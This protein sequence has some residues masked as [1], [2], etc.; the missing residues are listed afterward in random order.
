MKKMLTGAVAA[1]AM[2]AAGSASA[3]DALT[4]QLKW[5]TQA[6]FGGYYVIEAPDMDAAIEWAKK[7]PAAQWGPVEVRPYHPGF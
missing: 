4:L 3:A 1:A 5:V 6:Q 7:C 2:L